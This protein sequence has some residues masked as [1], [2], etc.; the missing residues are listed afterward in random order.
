MSSTAL[1]QYW[2][3]WVSIAATVG[4]LVAAGVTAWMAVRTAQMASATNDMA[5]TVRDELDLMKSEAAQR[6]DA[7]VRLLSFGLACRDPG[8]M[9]IGVDLYNG[10]PSDAY[11]LRCF[12]WY[13]LSGAVAGEKSEPLFIGRGDQQNVELNLWFYRGGEWIGQPSEEPEHFAQA[14][15]D[16]PKDFKLLVTWRDQRDR[17][18]AFIRALAGAAGKAATQTDLIAWPSDGGRGELLAAHDPLVTAMVSEPRM[19]ELLAE[20]GNRLRNM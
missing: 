14:V 16:S 4:T 7:A 6:A 3:L 18:W 15:T 11:D 12:G 10:G 13:G 19:D 1:L 9:T 20:V 17:Q 8:Q 5:Q 2:S